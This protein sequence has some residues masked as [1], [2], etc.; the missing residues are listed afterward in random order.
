MMTIERLI[1]FSNLIFRNRVQIIKRTPVCRPITNCM[2]R[3]FPVISK[4]TSMKIHRIVY[5]NTYKFCE[6]IGVQRD[7]TR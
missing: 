7:D 2:K 5:T 3:L 4:N 6:N 1:E